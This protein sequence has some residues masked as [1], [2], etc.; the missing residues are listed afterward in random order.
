MLKEKDAE[1]QG[2]LWRWIKY[3]K[4]KTQFLAC[5][6][7]HPCT[8]E[9]RRHSRASYSRDRFCPDNQGISTNFLK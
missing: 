2:W 6:A 7:T 8:K 9:N 4:I 1:G 5:A 3:G